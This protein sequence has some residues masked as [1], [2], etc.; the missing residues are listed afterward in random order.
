MRFPDLIWDARSIDWSLGSIGNGSTELTR[1]AGLLRGVEGFGQ[2]VSWRAQYKM[3][4]PES[5]N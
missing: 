3:L 1:Y 4:S 2:Y 5:P